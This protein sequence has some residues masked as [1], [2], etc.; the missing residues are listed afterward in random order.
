MLKFVYKKIQGRGWFGKHIQE[1]LERLRKIVQ[2]SIKDEISFTHSFSFTIAITF[3]PIFSS[4]ICITRD[5]FLYD[6][7]TLCSCSLIVFVP[8]DEVYLTVI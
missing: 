6:V 8:L 3:T 2:I 4:D 5:N 1:Q 7:N